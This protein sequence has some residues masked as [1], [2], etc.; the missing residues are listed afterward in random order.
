MILGFQP[1]FVPAVAAGTKPH[2]I[3]AGSRWRVGM[4]IQFYENVRQ[5]AMR[6]FRPDAV[7][8]VVQPV[9]MEYEQVPVGTKKRL[10]PAVHVGGRALTWLE[11]TELARRDGFDDF[12]EMFTWFK[13]AYGLP[14]TGQLIGWIDL[15]Y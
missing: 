7:A 5:K 3:R 11:A 9:V 14:F 8:R 4:S 6:K 12:H 1:R 2:T 10:V 15:R 13:K